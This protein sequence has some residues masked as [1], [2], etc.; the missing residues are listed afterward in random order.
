MALRSPTASTPG[1]SHS[2]VN[3]AGVLGT[4][5]RRIQKARF[6]GKEWDPL[7]RSPGRRIGS[8]SGEKNSLEMA[9]FG[10]F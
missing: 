6:G 1:D 3:M 5:Q 8:L 10:E 2:G 4:T 7:R 9:C